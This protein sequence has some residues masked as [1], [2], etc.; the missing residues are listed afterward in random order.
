MLKVFINPLLEIGQKDILFKELNS[1]A[2]TGKDVIECM[3]PVIDGDDWHIVDK[4]SAEG[5]GVQQIS[6]THDEIKTRTEKMAFLTNGK[7]SVQLLDWKEESSIVRHDPIVRCIGPDAE[8][9]SKIFLDN[10]LMKLVDSLVKIE[11]KEDIAK[12]IANLTG[13]NLESI[14]AIKGDL[15]AEK[16]VLI[17]SLLKMDQL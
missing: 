14:K 1:E 12:D 6:M 3:A 11:L 7:N 9:I 15:E 13:E 2:L 5:R 10:I 8:E 16:E 4:I 17:N